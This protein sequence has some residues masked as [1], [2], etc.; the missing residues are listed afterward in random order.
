MR[1]S[2]N[3][4]ARLIKENPMPNFRRIDAHHHMLPESYVSKL[5]RLG[6]DRS[7]GV[8]I[9]RWRPEDSLAI[10][11]AHGIESAI[12]S[13]SNPGVYFGDTDF[14]VRLARE[15]NEAGARIADSNPGRFGWFAIL[16]MPVVEPS[17]AGG[18]LR[19]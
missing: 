11:D 19:A 6:V 8:P 10:M 16:P 17:I 5:A 13:V 4:R 7:A 9:P 12:L 2:T 3:R 1:V 15:C 18:R 14:A